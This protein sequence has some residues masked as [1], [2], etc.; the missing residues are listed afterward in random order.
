ME[1]V[2]NCARCG[3]VLSGNEFCACNDMED[4]KR[5]NKAKRYIT[6][7]RDE[8][9]AILDNFKAEIEEDER[10]KTSYSVL[11]YENRVNNCYTILEALNKQLPRERYFDGVDTYICPTCDEE[12]EDTEYCPHCGQHLEL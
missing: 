6:N 8:N 12:V 4:L 10:G 1:N 3:K 7:I 11:V 2:C 9:F 5:L